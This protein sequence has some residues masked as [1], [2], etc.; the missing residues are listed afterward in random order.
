MSIRIATALF[1]P[2]LASAALAQSVT[3]AVD[4]PTRQTALVGDGTQAWTAVQPIGPL[5]GNGQVGGNQ[6]QQGAPRNATASWTSVVS[7]T[8]AVYRLS[9]WVAAHPGG[10]FSFGELGPSEQ[11]ITFTGVGAAFPW[12]LE[13]GLVQQPNMAG[14]L[15]S[16]DVGNDGSIDWTLTTFGP[17]GTFGSDLTAQPLSVRVVY[18]GTTTLATDA[19]A[20]LELRIVP[21]DVDTFRIATNCYNP[22]HYSVDPLIGPAGDV[23]IS[24]NGGFLSW[25]V[26]GFATTPTVLPISLTGTPLPCLAL[27]TPDWI[28]RSP[29]IFLAIPAAVRPITIHAQAINVV[30]TDLRLSDTFVI[31]AH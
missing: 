26:L 22:F 12:R 10:G 15:F 31:T 9:L 11:V 19:R 29:N 4:A 5:P 7:M 13:G 25:Q 24:S 27:P 6:I 17:V 20:T 3:I 16:V 21:G 18:H 28:H 30:G 2:L 14:P 23:L 8:G 1:L